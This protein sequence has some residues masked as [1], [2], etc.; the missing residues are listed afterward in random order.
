LF[1][2]RGGLNGFVILKY[3]EDIDPNYSYFYFE[4]MKII[5]LALNE[6]ID[7]AF[8]TAEKMLISKCFNIKK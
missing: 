7:T 3:H 2:L 6:E 5:D 8:L 1:A 4:E